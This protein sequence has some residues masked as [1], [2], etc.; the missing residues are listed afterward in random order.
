MGLGQGGTVGDP[1]VVTHIRGGGGAAG[2]G[3]GPT[4]RG[5]QT[6]SVG[7][8]RRRGAAQTG[9]RT[10]VGTGLRLATI[11]LGRGGWLNA[12][13][14]MEW[15]LHR[16]CHVVA[17]TET[18][19]RVASK[20]GLPTFID[21]VVVT[22]CRPE[23]GPECVWGGCGIA[24]DVG[25]ASP[26]QRATLL[27]QSDKADIIWVKLELRQRERPIL[28]ACAYLTPDS[29]PS[30]CKKDTDCQRAA[31]PKNHVQAGMIYL[32]ETAVK[33]A[34]MGDVVIA[35]DLNACC[36]RT[37][38]VTARRWGL[39]R[40]W[41]H[42]INGWSA[43]VGRPLSAYQT[44]DRG[45]GN[46]EV[47]LD[48]VVNG[49]MVLAGCPLWSVNNAVPA[50]KGTVAPTHGT[51]TLDHI[52]IGAAWDAGLSV[53]DFNVYSI[54]ALGFDH[55]APVVDLHIEGTQ[56]VG[57]RAPASGCVPTPPP[58]P[59]VQKS[60]SK[61]FYFSWIM[62]ACHSL[63][64][65]QALST[66]VKRQ[67]VQ[68]VTAYRVHCGV[69]VDSDQWVEGLYEALNGRLLMLK[70]H[71]QPH[72]A[73]LFAPRGHRTHLAAA[74]RALDRARKAMRR[75]MEGDVEGQVGSAPGVQALLRAKHAAERAVHKESRLLQKAGGQMAT[76]LL[77]EAGQRGDKKGMWAIVKAVLPTDGG[78]K[79]TKV[80]GLVQEFLD[81]TSVKPVHSAID[82]VGPRAEWQGRLSPK[83]AAR[84]AAEIHASYVESVVRELGA[85]DPSFDGAQYH[86]VAKQVEVLM[87]QA[88][89]AVA[90][91]VTEGSVGGVGP[92]VPAG[93][94]LQAILNATVSKQE[95]E[96]ALR[97]VEASS[98]T[99]GSA[100]YTVRT[101]MSVL[102]REV[103]GSAEA[104]GGAPGGE[105]QG[106][107]GP[108]QLEPDPATELNIEALLC[109]IN[110]SWV[111]A[112]P[113]LRASSVNVTPIFKSG[114]PTKPSN[115]RTI[116]VGDVQSKLL[117]IVLERRLTSYLLATKAIHPLQSGFQPGRD[118]VEQILLSRLL[119][120]AG[121]RAGARTQSVYMDLSRAYGNVCHN[122][123]LQKLAAAGIEGRMFLFLAKWLRQQ[124]MN[125][126]VDGE[127]SRWFPAQ[128]GVP[129]GASL[130]PILFLLYF[131]E[132]LVAA[133]GTDHPGAGVPVSV[134]K[135]QDGKP[136][137]AKVALQ[138]Y[139]DDVKSWARITA[140]TQAV[141]D[142]V[143]KVLL[144][145][146]FKF[147]VG[148]TK[149]AALGECGPPS[150]GPGGPGPPPDTITLYLPAEAVAG[151]VPLVEGEV[152]MIPVAALYRY[153]GVLEAMGEDGHVSYSA[154]LQKVACISRDNKRRVAVSRIAELPIGVGAAAVVGLLLPKLTY[155]AAVWSN[156]AVPKDV[157]KD[158]DGVIHML[159]HTSALP[160]EAAHALTGVAPLQHAIDTLILQRIVAV[161]R[162]PR[163]SIL[164]GAVTEE[165]LL[166][167]N[168]GTKAAVRKGL[169][170]NSVVTVLRQVTAAIKWNHDSVDNAPH[171]APPPARPASVRP[172]DYDM[173]EAPTDWL[174]LVL[175]VLLFWEHGTLEHEEWEVV[176]NMDKWRYEAMQVLRFHRRVTTL[177]VL[178]SMNGIASLLTTQ[179]PPPFIHQPWSA[180][181]RYRVLAHGG[182]C[183]LIGREV[184]KAITAKGRWD[185]MAETGSA[186]A[187]VR[188]CNPPGLCPF[189]DGPLTVP[190]LARDCPHQVLRGLRVRYYEECRQYL[191]EQGSTGGAVQHA[192]EDIR[193]K[194]KW[195]RVLMGHEVHGEWLMGKE[196]VVEPSEEDGGNGLDEWWADYVAEEE[197][198]PRSRTPT[199]SRTKGSRLEVWPRLLSITTALWRGIISRVVAEVDPD[200]AI[201]AAAKKKGRTTQAARTRTRTPAP[202][203][204]PRGRGLVG[205]VHQNR[206]ASAPGRGG[207]AGRRGRA[208]APPSKGA[209]SG[210]AKDGGPVTRARARATAL[211]QARG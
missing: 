68:E 6:K 162:A 52:L 48:G 7:P 111:P 60:C 24:V 92:P 168:P 206:C 76:Q 148:L 36:A 198:M 88:E 176:R 95:L 101:G 203:G 196:R 107:S 16:G 183:S 135:R 12:G 39:L 139:A 128:K 43:D 199:C 9:P 142:R 136:T 133:E 126:V 29:C 23:R 160:K 84:Q 161:C 169:W 2:P 138:G 56:L 121:G 130:S 1:V 172:R 13:K 144:R 200:G 11:N 108:T 175:R 137:P 83:E 165:L 117:Q 189:C 49:D 181:V 178:S 184:Y 18:H 62:Q 82:V 202:Q 116:A 37:N 86:E 5:R 50:K 8:P 97:E 34:R 123:L 4:T 154:H 96:G 145:L 125:I 87:A 205:S 120:A 55:S 81:G 80:T 192:V 100:S 129:E 98:S 27:D 194:G 59:D 73:R 71:L 58:N 193:V 20:P 42:V 94:N 35:G 91:D 75:T 122:I 190:H 105:R 69:P 150:P 51:G 132:V 118:T 187:P 186:M 153:L 204:K 38:H 19:H 170:I 53:V 74:M 14:A 17:F 10:P 131:N 152:V 89:H 47:G 207:A 31:C 63:A 22:N 113:S 157:Q 99:L 140:G 159:L 114:D 195:F 201:R 40:D 46:E 147:N 146:R 115:Y 124:R 188:K 67:L 119:M 155:G 112:N 210:V 28:L 93:D 54:K 167:R 102:Y 72:K 127:H 211:A 164:R 179:R 45:G 174:D 90:T 64:G 180:G 110:A 141:L 77:A 182:V 171:G 173:E 166:W 3:N 143:Q 134:F 103:E 191:I 30:R 149:T 26:I 41:L 156:G 66:Y 209:P 21:T 85:E 15:A 78:A 33:H 158:L 197:G 57:Q 70:D 61:D 104:A 208:A 185:W 151:M 32:R 65:V 163:G 106:G 44:R 79:G 109:S 177:W 25:P